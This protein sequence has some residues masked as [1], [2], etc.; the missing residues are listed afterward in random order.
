MSYTKRT[1]AQCGIRKPQPEMFRK[2]TYVETGNSRQ[3]VSGRTFLGAMLDDSKSKK[4]VDS[5]LLNSNQRTYS[6]KKIVWLCGTCNGAANAGEIFFKIVAG[7]ILL[8]ILLALGL[9]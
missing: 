9:L 3:G 1:C 8:V 6:R 2:E 4:A 7:I 5:W